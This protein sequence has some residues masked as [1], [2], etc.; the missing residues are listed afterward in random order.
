MGY[1]EVPR[2]VKLRYLEEHCRAYWFP[3][4]AYVRRRGH[5]KEDAEDLTQAFFVAFLQ[6]SSANGLS[7]C[8]ARSGEPF[9]NR[10][11]KRMN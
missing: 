3:L 8:W 11:K 1:S 6:H 2:G 5:S 10:I 7:T 4:Y 9:L